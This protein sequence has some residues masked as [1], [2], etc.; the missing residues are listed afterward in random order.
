MA[1]TKLTGFKSLQDLHDF[2]PTEQSCIDYL[3]S[4]RWPGGKVTCPYCGSEKVYTLKGKTKR[5]KCAASS[6]KGA[7]KCNRLFS[8]RINTPFEDS[9]LP[10]K[11]WYV[12]LFLA[13]NTSKGVSS[14]NL[15]KLVNITQANAWHLIHR[16]REMMR[17]DAPQLIVNDTEV[18][19]CYIGGRGKNRPRSK[20]DNARGRSM[21]HKTPVFGMLE[22]GGR[23]VAKVVIDTKARTIQPIMRQHIAI[24]TTVHTDEYLAY[25]GVEKT[26]RHLVVKHGKGEYVTYHP[27]GEYSSTNGM[28]G[29]WSLLKKGLNAVYHSVS[30]FHLQQYVNEY[31]ARYNQRKQSNQERFDNAL[32][33]ADGRTMPYNKLV[34]KK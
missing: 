18:D 15:A 23:V 3:A 22:R 27:T 4:I 29:Y 17:E 32:K 30:P 11:T 25:K 13:T 16:C 14:A 31:S 26:F 21:K 7:V 1:T 19:E 33:Q 10:L 6:K 28:E 12:A 20:R 5:W 34:A 2:F 24:G 9:N 8:V